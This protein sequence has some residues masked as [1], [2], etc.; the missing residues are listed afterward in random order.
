MFLSIPR[1]S[2][3]K[4][5]IGADLSSS[6]SNWQICINLNTDSLICIAHRRERER[7]RDRETEQ[8]EENNWFWVFFYTSYMEEVFAGFTSPWQFP[9]INLCVL[10]CGCA[11]LSF[12]DLFAYCNTVMMLNV[13]RSDITIKNLTW[14]H[15][16]LEISLCAS[17]TVL[18]LQLLKIRVSCLKTLKD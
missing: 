11:C 18:Q 8:K 6:K 10:F 15:N 4:L 1:W 16:Y 14:Y 2:R 7:D 3:P 13:I 9:R 5:F 17:K 12:S